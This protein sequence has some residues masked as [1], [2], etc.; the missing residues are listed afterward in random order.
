MIIFTLFILVCMLLAVGMAIDTVRTEFARIKIQN[1][2]D[3]AVLAAADL[4]QTLDPESVVEDYLARA[5][6]DPELVNINVTSALDAR[7]VSVESS[8]SVRT[9]FMDMIGIETLSAPA[10]G[11]AEESVT[12][13]EIVLVLDNSGSMSNNNNFRLNLLKEAA[14]NFVD[15]VLE[16]DSSEGKVAISIVP[17]ATQVN[18]G[19][20]L[21]SH[22][23]VTDEH[24]HSSCLTFE[25]DDFLTTAMPTTQEYNRTAHFDPS[26]TSMPA[27]E[28]YRVCRNDSSRQITPWSD[29]AV[30]LKSQINDMVGFGWTSIEIGTKWGAALLDPSAQP[31]V[32]AMIAD[33]IVDEKFAGQ[34]FDYGSSEE[35]ISRMKYL[36]VMSDGA[37]TNQWEV[38]DP[39][40]SG[41]S[42]IFL[43][44]GLNN[45]DLGTESTSSIRSKMSFYDEDRASTSKYYR[46]N[47]GS[48][49]DTPEGEND[50]VQLSWP[51]IWDMMSVEYY[52]D[53]LY[54]TALGESGSTEYNKI[55]DK[56]GSSTKKGRTWD[57]CG[58]AAAT[59]GVLVFTIGMDTYGE[60]DET[61]KECATDTTYFYDVSTDED[62]GAL[63]QAFTS[64]ARTINQLR[65]TN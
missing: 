14:G 33:G 38:D 10:S 53:R 60:G 3:S 22:Y 49:N 25:A 2:I 23:T 27:N 24:S 7:Q 6:I 34:P 19:A 21:L 36:I 16:D 39:Y 46:F 30:Y 26:T 62:V 13:L 9:M 31:V 56:W 47:N 4:D 57:I 64:I 45:I 5:G 15:Q 63:D 17:F 8:F 54:A 48:W 32:T 20:D 55:V 18:A 28:N 35:G 37:N 11:T 12:E 41:L 50:A 40:R 65:L 1:T 29:D 58:A 52:T 61:L 44:G 42:P 43:D 59:E 51:D